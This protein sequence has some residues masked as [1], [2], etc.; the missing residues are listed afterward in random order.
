[1]ESVV[2]S[3]VSTFVS[4]GD[5]WRDLAGRDPAA[6]IFH[7]PE[8]LG[9]WWTEFGTGGTL[10]VI[11]VRDG[12]TLIGIVPLAG[13]EDGVTR[14]VGDP[15]VTDYL[16]PVS[17]A[18]HRAD[19]AAAALTRT[20][21]RAEFG[22]L[23]ADSGWPEAFR[24][25]AKRAGRTWTETEQDVCPRVMLDGWDGYLSALSGKLRHEIR[26][27]ERR[28][29][30]AGSVSARVSDAATIERDL[31]VFLDFNR[32]AEAEKADFFSHRIREAFFSALTAAFTNHGLLRNVVLQF[33][34]FPVAVAVGFSYKGVWSLYNSAFS[35]EHGALAPGMVL[36]SETIRLAA[37]EG[38]RSLDFLRG[39]E[40]Y[41][42]RFGATDVPIVQ[43]AIE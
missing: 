5:E 36:V 3:D 9:L 39:R 15:D 40:E 42:Y 35:R 6:A 38:C 10:R 31:E 12:D 22:G 30:E 43:I 18:D 29:R 33:E 37:E 8:Y 20:T 26:R 19:V 21:G 1:M 25:A 24:D 11:E 34:G 17:R 7:R 16:G 14:F 23:A 27:K 28:M 2:R 32:E 13:C 4:L 41:K